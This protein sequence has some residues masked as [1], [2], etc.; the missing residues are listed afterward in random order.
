MDAFQDEWLESDSEGSGTGH[1]VTTGTP[2]T[3]VDAS[4]LAVH[5]ASAPP[6]IPVGVVRLPSPTDRFLMRDDDHVVSPTSG[7]P[8]FQNLTLAAADPIPASMPMVLPFE[9]D[10]EDPEVRAMR[11][12]IY[13]DRDVWPLESREEAMLFRH[14]I[15]RLSICVSDSIAA[16]FVPGWMLTIVLMSPTARRLRSEPVL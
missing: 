4:G 9:T 7:L 10:A 8:G 3:M 2:S 5:S 15:Q 16:S 14:Y 11:A 12:K 1:T 13:R 6:A